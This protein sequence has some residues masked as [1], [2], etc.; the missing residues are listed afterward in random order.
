MSK[1][2]AR[3]ESAARSLAPAPVIVTL[4]PDLIKAGRGVRELAEALAGCHNVSAVFATARG[5]ILRAEV[6]ERR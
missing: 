1:R 5:H 6:P 2:A 4:T 3:R